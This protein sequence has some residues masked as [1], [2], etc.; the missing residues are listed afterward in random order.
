MA[1][2]TLSDVSRDLDNRFRYHPPKDTE[3]AQKHE[4]I[5]TAMRNTAALITGLCPAGRELSTA[6]RKLEEAMMWANAAIARDNGQ[7]GAGE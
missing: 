6:V 3:T 1:P 7:E 2:R 4:S 5:R